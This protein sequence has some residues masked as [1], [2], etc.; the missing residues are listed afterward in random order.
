MVKFW[1]IVPVCR[2]SNC[3]CYI[4][5]VPAVLLWDRGQGQRYGLGTDSP[6]HER[7]IFGLYPCD[8]FNNN[9]WLELFSNLIFVIQDNV[10]H[11]FF[12][13]NNIKNKLY[14]I[15]LF[16]IWKIVYKNEIFHN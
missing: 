16:L 13:S 8:Y 1:G 9:N 5:A 7:H 2:C 6:G 14:Y 12:Y 10:I 3:C 15:V 4:V 11:F